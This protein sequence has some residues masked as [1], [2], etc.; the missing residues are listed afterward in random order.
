MNSKWLIGLIIVTLVLVG[1][2]FSGGRD[3][4][5]TS[6]TQAPAQLLPG[7]ENAINDVDQIHI[8]VGGE[9]TAATLTRNDDG[10]WSVGERNG[11]PADLE[12]VRALLIGLSQAKKLESKTADPDRYAR[13]GVLDIADADADGVE[14]RIRAPEEDHA[15][16]LGDQA[17]DQD[18]T[19][20]RI[21][22]DAQTWLID[23]TFNLGDKPGDW[24]APQIIS[25]EPTSLRRLEINPPDAEPFVIERITPEDDW[26][27]TPN[28]QGREPAYPGALEQPARAVTDL[29]L[30]DVSPAADVTMPE[31]TRQLVVTTFD[32]LVVSARS[33]QTDDDTLWLTLEAGAVPPGAVADPS[34]I[35]TDS[36]AAAGTT[37]EASAAEAEAQRL[38]DLW[39]GW[40]YKVPGYRHVQWTAGVDDVLAAAAEAQPESAPA[41]AGTT[42]DPTT[43]VPAGA[44]PDSMEP[45]TETTEGTTPSEA[46]APADGTAPSDESAAT[47]DEATP[48]AADPVPPAEDVAPA[49]DDPAEPAEEEAPATG[50]PVAPTDETAPPTDTPAATTDDADSDSSEEEANPDGTPPPAQ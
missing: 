13:L 47:A 29:D 14:V 10:N 33:W 7:L 24:L 42:P 22:G 21:A 19:Y 38:N 6:A 15:V 36:A 3:E 30:E 26:T 4:R 5:P 25:L 2:A 37:G 28:P 8:V 23:K 48:A 9:A 34:T 11:Y 41:D 1:L 45:A 32:G 31:T 44:A 40:V 27:L 18:G 35:S 43:D 49:T 20:A 17:S 12:A 39:N 50:E 46:D 16:I